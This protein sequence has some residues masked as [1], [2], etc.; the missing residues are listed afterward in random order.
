[1]MDV[2]GTY[3]GNHFTIYVNKT[4]YYAVHL[5]FIVKYVNYFSIKPKGKIYLL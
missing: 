5:K 1:M 3:C 2:S 4:V